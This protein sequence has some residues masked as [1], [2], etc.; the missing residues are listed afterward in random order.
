MQATN[1]HMD[2]IKN[3]VLLG[4]LKIFNKLHVKI[5]NIFPNAELKIDHDPALTVAIGC[6][7]KPHDFA[8]NSSEV[9]K[10]CKKILNRNS[11]IKLRSSTIS[12][13]EL[14]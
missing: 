8:L 14:V 9:F 5:K 4:D 13:D 12:Q 2:K 10:F 11:V 6:A 7:K 1:D 3:I